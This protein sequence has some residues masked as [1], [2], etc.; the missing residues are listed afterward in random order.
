MD[1]TNMEDV[2]IVYD[3]TQVVRNSGASPSVMELYDIL[4]NIE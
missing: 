4:K 3:T 1:M 2:Q